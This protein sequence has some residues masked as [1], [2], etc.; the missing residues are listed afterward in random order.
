VK[1]VAK[2]VLWTLGVALVV[3][4]AVGLRLKSD[5]ERVAALRAPP[6][7]KQDESKVSAKPVRVDVETV[8]GQRY[9]ETLAATGTLLAQEGVELQ[10]EANG[11]VVRINFKEGSKVRAGELLVKLNDAD[12]R[13]SLDRALH[14]QEL[15]AVREKRL[16]QLVRER[17]VTQD[18]YDVARS[19]MEVQGSEVE[20][21]RAQI[22]KTEIRAPFEGV[23]GL[24]H[25][26]EGAFVNAATR[27]ATLQQIDR[28]KVDFAI[29][30][31]YA[32]RIA[33]GQRVNFR[34]AGSDR[35]HV[36]HVYAIDPRIDSATRTVL[37]RALC[38]NPEG[39]L[40]PGSFASLELTIADIPAA[41]LIPA[42]A[43]VPG[44]DGKL[45]YVVQDGVAHRRVVQIGNRTSQAVQVVEGLAAGEQIVVS[46]LQQMR[47]GVE[48]K[49]LAPLARAASA[50][51]PERSP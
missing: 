5:S 45:V 34:V 30:E 16:L 14:R 1:S 33:P 37:I 50:A 8:K 10:A 51:V 39:H 19:E 36:G 38:D 13:A 17:I 2:T 29:P 40:L 49:A 15:A 20:L 24:R 21:I 7:K 42:E 23:V 46:G 27:V 48:V 28:L 32:P 44:V 47:D 6:A 12:L 9:A 41:L 22:A 35:V 26:S 25:V 43:V 3:G 31:R 18:D 4:G 11:R